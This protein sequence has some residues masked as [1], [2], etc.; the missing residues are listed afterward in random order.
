MPSSRP[1]I[2]AFWFQVLSVARR[3][4][5]VVLSQMKDNKGI[6]S[7][8]G[9]SSQDSKNNKDQGYTAATLKA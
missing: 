5:A 8:N 9:N 3:L 1:A 6:R 7:N 2:T 4:M